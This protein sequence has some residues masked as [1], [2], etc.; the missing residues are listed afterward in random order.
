MTG[1]PNTGRHFVFLAPP[2]H[3]HV[4][5]TLPLVE[6]LV[7]RG[8]RVSY[9]T[10]EPLLETVANTG[11]TVIP[12]EWKVGRDTPSDGPAFTVE[13][14]A[15]LFQGLLAAG[16]GF[17]PELTERLRGEEVAAV[18]YDMFGVVGPALAHRLGVPSVALLP[19]FASNEHFNMGSVLPDSG[20]A[21]QFAAVF[22]GFRAQL[23]EFAAEEGADPAVFDMMGGAGSE[24]KLVFIP[25]SFQ[26][27]GDTFDKRYR[28]I[29]PSLGSR[30]TSSE[31]AP[32]EDAS[33]LLF[34]SLGTVFNECPEFFQL[35]LQAF[36]DTDWRVAMSLGG[37]RDLAELGPIPANFDV[38]PF[39][40]Q[41]VVLA[42]AQAFV[43]HTGMNS[44]MEA[45][46]HGVPIV[47]VPQMPEQALN[48]RR[49][50]ELGCG[51]QLDPETLT[52]EQLRQAVEELVGDPAVRANL[53]RVSRE[54][55]AC[56]GAAEG[57]DALEDHV[58]AG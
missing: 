26:V 47:S 11:A 41:P 56:G 7:A 35:C 8:H 19:S 37:Q 57:A 25:R 30:A 34:V 20:E 58:S 18:C 42:H 55:R 23:A 53:D 12:V 43:S 27:A 15:Q 49:V 3:G 39:F 54:V 28:F 17:L 6:E 5:P 40:P 46:Y 52:A 44:T 10:A 2:A 1:T 36:G 9:V 51:R 24:L 14:L 31:W 45:L 16:R 22:E 38:R 32:P 50:Q 33:P 29:G 21:E 48:G 13:G 4:N